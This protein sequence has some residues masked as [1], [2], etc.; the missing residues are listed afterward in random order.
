MSRVT[1]VQL[2]A[3]Q[4]EYSSEHRHEQHFGVVAGN[5]FVGGAHDFADVGAALHPQCRAF[6]QG[7]AHGHENT[8]RQAL[9]CHV[10]NHEEQTVAVEFEEIVEIAA[11]RFRGLD[12][13]LQAKARVAVEFGG[14]RR[15]HAHLDALR[16]L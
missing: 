2:A 6:V 12:Q 15:Q 14:R 11:D 13:G 3:L 1:P 5:L 4:V 7:L 9:A 8:G 10:A 16:G